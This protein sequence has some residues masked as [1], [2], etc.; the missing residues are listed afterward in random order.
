MDTA[1][2]P[3]KAGASAPGSTSQAGA[4]NS[5]ESVIFPRPR[6]V[7]WCATQVKCLPPCTDAFFS[8]PACACIPMENYLT[9]L[10]TGHIRR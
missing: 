2:C 9:D 10:Q 5:S 6:V 8:L 4:S 7:V 1:D 3:K